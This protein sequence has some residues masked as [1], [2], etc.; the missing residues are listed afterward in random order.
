MIYDVIWH[1]LAYFTLILANCLAI[2]TFYL[3]SKRSSAQK[4]R[5]FQRFFYTAWLSVV[6]G[7]YLKF[8]EHI[9]MTVWLNFVRID[10]TSRYDSNFI[11]GT[12]KVLGARVF[13]KMSWWS[14]PIVHQLTILG[15]SW[16]A[17]KT[18]PRIFFSSNFFP[19]I[20]FL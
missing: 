5:V 15:R 6:T 19:L 1:A 7:R 3:I 9:T 4:I 13:L 20:F 10:F 17:K 16:T 11:I 8:N 18:T 2:T 14:Q 12:W